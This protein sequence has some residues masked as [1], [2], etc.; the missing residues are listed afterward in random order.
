MMYGVFGTVTI[1]AGAFENARKTLRD[2]IVPR[3]KQVPGFVKGYWAISGDHTQGS[4]LL[5]FDSKSNADNA[6]KMATEGPMPPGV[7][8]ASNEVREIVADA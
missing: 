6:A 7:T 5:V 4:S 3:A 1:A 2:E 8:M